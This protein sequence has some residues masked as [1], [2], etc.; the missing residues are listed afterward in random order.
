[1]AVTTPASPPPLAVTERGRSLVDRATT[2]LRALLALAVTV[3]V[4]HYGDMT[5]RFDDYVAPDPS[6]PGSLVTHW[7]VP[8]SWV[9]F[10]AVGLLGYLRFRAGRWP[11]AAALIGAYSAQGLVDV[12]HYQDLS[13]ADLSAFQNTTIVGGVVVGVAVLGFAIWTAWVLPRRT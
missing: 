9:V 2:V 6:F 11:I 4:L 7:L 8:V 13:P 5:L 3:S 10:T 12:G 1:M